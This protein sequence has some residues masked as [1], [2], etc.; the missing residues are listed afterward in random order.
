MKDSRLNDLPQT[1]DPVIAAIG[2]DGLLGRPLSQKLREYVRNSQPLLNEAARNIEA[3][4][5]QLET[6][7]SGFAELNGACTKLAIH[8]EDVPPGGVELS[9]LF[10]RDLFGNTFKVFLDEAKVIEHFVVQ[11]SILATGKAEHP[12]LKEMSSSEPTVVLFGVSAA[13]IVLVGKAIDVVLNAYGKVQKIRLARAAAEAAEAEA[14]VIKSLADQANAKIK[15]EIEDFISAR[16]ADSSVK[17]KAAE[18]NAALVALETALV[19]VASWIDRGLRIDFSA[20]EK[21]VAEGDG[22]EDDGTMALN[23]EIAEIKSIAQK[24]ANWRL[25]AEPIL[26]L[27]GPSDEDQTVDDADQSLADKS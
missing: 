25:E 3:V 5:Q 23:V 4:R 27:P 1:W 2:L 10:P 7:M 26:G 24:I 16:K 12:Q 21:Q 9:V 6:A 22:S 19:K 14:S 18:K 20:K 13:T 15:A 17:I 11:A 8:A